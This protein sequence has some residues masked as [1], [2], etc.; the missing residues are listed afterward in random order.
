MTSADIL[1]LTAL[2]VV[3]LASLALLAS[4]IGL[5]VHGIRKPNAA[6]EHDGNRQQSWQVERLVYRHHRL[7]GI[8]ITLGSAWFLWQSLQG[9]ALA[10]T[11]T[12]ISW[13]VFW[14]TLTGAHACTFLIGLVILL[15]PSRLKP[16]ESLANRRFELDLPKIERHETSHPA[17]NGLVLILIATVV[18]TGMGLL[19]LER[20]GAMI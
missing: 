17:L 11:I 14:S 13:T 12:S 4:G 19:L 6:V 9:A 1:V 10:D 3:A 2:L 16:I 8:L 7:A 5:V 20:L 18:L 15:K